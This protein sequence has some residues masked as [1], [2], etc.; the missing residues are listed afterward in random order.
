MWISVLMCGSVMSSCMVMCGYLGSCKVI[1]SSIVMHGL[2]S[3]MV[4]YGY[5][6]S[7]IFMVWSCMVREKWGIYGN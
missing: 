3:Y 4:K 2:W 5:V 7:S 6:W 1:W